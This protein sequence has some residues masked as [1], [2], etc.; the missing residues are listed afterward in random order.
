MGVRAVLGLSVGVRAVPGLSI[1]MM[2]VPGLFRRE[3]GTRFV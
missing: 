1:G 3:G 2:A